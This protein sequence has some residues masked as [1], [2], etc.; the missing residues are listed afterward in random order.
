MAPAITTAVFAALY[1]QARADAEKYEKS[2]DSL[3]SELMELKC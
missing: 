3:C 2:A 1:F